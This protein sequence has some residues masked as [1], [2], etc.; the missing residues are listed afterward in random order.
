VRAMSKGLKRRIVSFSTAVSTLLVYIPF[1]D[2]RWAIYAAMCVGYTVAV[3]GLAWSD[4]KLG[5]FSGNR[6]I[7]SVL[8]A[9]LAFILA[10]I[11]WIWLAQYSRPFLPGWLTAEG[12]RH[13]SWFLL[14]VLLGIVGILLYEHW[15]L[16]VKPNAALADSFA[17][18][19]ATGGGKN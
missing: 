19:P 6:S 1:M 4:N 11:L 8:R 12:D 17:V 10:V 15:W 9:H 3:F 18:P 16:S 13:E 14:F 7:G 2:T 5:S